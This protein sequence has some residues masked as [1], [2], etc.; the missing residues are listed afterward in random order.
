VIEELFKIIPCNLNADRE[1]CSLL[2]FDK[3]LNSFKNFINLIDICILFLISDELVRFFKKQTSIV[4]NI[5]EY[6]IESKKAPLNA[7]LDQIWEVSD[8]AHSDLRFWRILSVTVTLCFVRNDHLKVCFR[9]EGAR[10]QQGLL[11]PDTA[12]INVKAGFDIVNSIND[13]TEALPELVIKNMLRFSS[14]ENLMRIN[15]QSIVN[16]IGDVTSC[17]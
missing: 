10:L 1:V 13:K 7:M 4:W 17:L 8:G 6:V 16:S 3:L 12:R 5:N 11:V 15:I 14:Y 9:S 2:K